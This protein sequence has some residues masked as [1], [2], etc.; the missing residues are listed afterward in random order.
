MIMSVL[1]DLELSD[2]LNVHILQEVGSISDML[3]PLMGGLYRFVDFW[4]PR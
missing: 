1:Y 2:S 3:R 4:L